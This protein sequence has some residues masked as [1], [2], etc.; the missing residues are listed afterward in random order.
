MLWKVQQ[1]LMFK[2]NF[3]KNFPAP[4]YII[5]KIFIFWNENA[6]NELHF[7]CYNKCSNYTI[8]YKQ[9]IIMNLCS[10]ITQEL[11]ITESALH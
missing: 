5:Q 11:L 2:Y 4:S 9:Q 8:Y 3:D 1:K 6:T 7:V 10:L